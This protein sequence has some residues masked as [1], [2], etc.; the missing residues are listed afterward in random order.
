[1]MP[2]PGDALLTAADARGAL[3]AVA[4][5]REQLVAAVA[6]VIVG[7][8]EVLDDMLAVMLCGGHCLL[9]GVPGLAKTLLVRSLAAASICSL[10]ESSSRPT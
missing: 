4:R 7:Q 8:R 9:E 3:T 5:L 1:M 6:P 2:G 10:G